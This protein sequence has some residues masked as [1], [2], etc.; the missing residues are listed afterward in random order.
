MFV[1]LTSSP[2]H[3][4]LIYTC[5]SHKLHTKWQSTFLAEKTEYNDIFNPKTLNRTLWVHGFDRLGTSEEELAEYFGTVPG[6]ESFKKRV[7][8]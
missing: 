1:S 4:L 3:A 2:L 8:R 6:A 5:R 7:F